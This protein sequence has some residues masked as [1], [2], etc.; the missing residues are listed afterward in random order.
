MGDQDFGLSF[1]T[2]SS[3]C[4]QIVELGKYEIAIVVGA[5]NFF[6]GAQHKQFSRTT[7]DEIGMFGTVMNGLALKEGL[8]LK[9][10]HAHVLCP[11]FISGISE[12]CTIDHA[13]RYLEQKEIV[14]CV[15][16]TGAPF[17]TTDTAA[18]LRACELECQ[19]VF[20]AT[21]VDGVYSEDPKKNPNALFY[22]F[23]THCQVWEQ[24]LQVMDLTAMTLAMENKMPIV[25]F[26]SKGEN[27]LREGIEM[28]RQCTVVSSV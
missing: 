22:P 15:G 6:R 11:R 24:K 14:I 18:I 10:K 8:Q 25:I 2:I 4:R 12:G 19:I 3:I 26:S 5:G 23:L 17:F 27:A 9:G 13:K 28:K 20:K 16:G 1:A 7:A 21:N